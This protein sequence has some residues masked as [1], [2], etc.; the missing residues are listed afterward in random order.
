MSNHPKTLEE[1]QRRLLQ[2]KENKFRE[3]CEKT[4]KEALNPPLN[5][6]CLFVGIAFIVM[7][8]WITLVILKL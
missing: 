5:K 2:L 1:A 7:L 4:A 8:V 3:E 6:G